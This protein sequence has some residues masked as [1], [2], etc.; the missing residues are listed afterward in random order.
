M[1]PISC[2]VLYDQQRGHFCSHAPRA[3]WII[4]VPGNVSKIVIEVIFADF[5]LDVEAVIQMYFIL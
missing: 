1:F 2:A 3:C 5:L 4:V